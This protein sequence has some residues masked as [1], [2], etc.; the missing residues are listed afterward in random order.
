MPRSLAATISESVVVAGEVDVDAVGE[1]ISLDA[2][3]NSFL[4][5]PMDRAS[6]GSFW[7]PQRKMIAMTAMTTSHSYPTSANGFHIHIALHHARYKNGEVKPWRLT[8]LVVTL[9]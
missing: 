5:I 6:S 1:L 7:G 8:V 2:F 4:A 9:E 3:S